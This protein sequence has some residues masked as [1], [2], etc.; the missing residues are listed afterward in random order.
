MSLALKTPSPLGG[1]W[2]EEAADKILEP[3]VVLWTCQ[4]RLDSLGA[5]GNGVR[6]AAGRS[7]GGN[8]FRSQGIIFAAA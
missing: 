5:D 3:A 2:L 1:F 8:M 4:E 7:C 6:S